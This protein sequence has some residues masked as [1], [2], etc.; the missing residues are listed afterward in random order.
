[1]T[2]IRRKKVFPVIWFLVLILS[3]AP[4]AADMAP[5]VYTPVT[6]THTTKEKIFDIAIW[7]PLLWAGYYASQP[8]TVSKIRIGDFED[9]VFRRGAVLWDGDAF[10][11]NFIG[12]P[13]IGSEYYLYFR[14]RGYAPK[15]A[16]LNA[17]IVSTIF[18]ETVETF[19]EP[20]S[21]NDFIITPVLGSVLGW[22]RERAGLRLVNSDN[23]LHRVMGH[24]IYLET[25]APFFEKVEFAPMLSS[26]FKFAGLAFQAQF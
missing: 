8:E 3:V 9:N 4:V 6:R 22:A 14:S 20:F 16:F 26:D 12:H 17:A 24:I 5:R 18:E 11:W 15:W 7:Y 19:S 13:Y 21:A 1:M 2:G 25:N 10:Y 23:K